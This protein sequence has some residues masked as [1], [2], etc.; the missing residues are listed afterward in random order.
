M[1]GLVETF[2][3]DKEVVFV[4]RLALLL[5]QFDDALLESAVGIDRV[6]RS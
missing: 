1:V 3:V 6:L 5:G 2:E 4:G